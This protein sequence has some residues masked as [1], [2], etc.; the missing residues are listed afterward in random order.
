MQ[1]VT[2]RCAQFPTLEV[3]MAS[4]CIARDTFC[5]S[6]A[7]AWRARYALRPTDYMN[8]DFCTVRMP[9]A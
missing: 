8:H 5:M 7:H 9:I 3:Y 2:N 6:I 4:G 1:T